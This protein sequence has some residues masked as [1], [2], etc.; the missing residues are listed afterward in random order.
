M[1]ISKELKCTRC[2][3]G[4]QFWRE[5]NLQLS[6]NGFGS[7]MANVMAGVIK[8]KIYACPECKK[9]ELI[10]AEE[11]PFINGSDDDSL[12]CPDCET[13]HSKSSVCPVCGYTYKYCP[14]CDGINYKSAPRCTRCGFDFTAVKEKKGLAKFF[15]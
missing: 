12:L 8:T 5:E 1:Y 15:G 2:G 10:S 4:M 11:I 13:T 6:S 9:L 7:N 14:D 3:C